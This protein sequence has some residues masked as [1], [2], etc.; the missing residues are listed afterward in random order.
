MLL[1]IAATAAL[2]KPI[3]PHADGY[4]SCQ[5]SLQTQA[6]STVCPSGSHPFWQ[7]SA[8]SLECNTGCQ[9][10]ACNAAAGGTS[11]IFVLGNLWHEQYRGRDCAL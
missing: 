9:V 4:L 2:E 11:H 5:D 8:L 10:G 1:Y 7:F 6:A 3:W